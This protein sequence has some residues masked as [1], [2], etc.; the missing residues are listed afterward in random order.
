VRLAAL[1]LLL[2][3]ACQPT[4]GGDTPSPTL[5][6]GV[7]VA[8]DTLVPAVITDTLPGDSDD[9]AIWIAPGGADA[10]ILGTDKGDVTGGVY[11]F[12]L[13]GRIDLAHSVTPLR[14]MNNVDVRQ[15]VVLG[16]DTVD[17]AVATERRR[18]R[19]RVFHLPDMRPM[20]RGGVVVFDGDTAREPM[21]VALYRRPRD[22]AL[23]AIVGGKSGPADG[24]LWQYRLEPDGQGA[25]RATKVRAFGRYSGRK[26]IEAIV[27]DDALG[28]VYYS[29]EGVGVRKYHADPDSGNAELALLATTGVADDHEGLALYPTGPGTGY[30]LLS[31]QGANRLQLFTREG[32]PGAPH[33]HRRVAVIPVRA[34]E[35]DGV[36]VTATPLPGFPQGLLVM[37]SNRGAF[38]YYDWRD[39]A[40]HLPPAV[41][42]VAP[43]SAR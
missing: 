16:T 28:Y 8:A 5:V 32:A 1:S 43:P 40:R 35:T 6:D 38:H 27:A 20:D 30:L 15:R 41:P 31:D 33:D 11:Q 2:L 3:A 36:E 4:P 10:R 39:V 17:L 18:G 19:L 12:D 29:D 42:P 23:F 37:M 21:G 13:Q 7:A 24:Y 22:G 25:V 14:R 26:E 34:R 9:P